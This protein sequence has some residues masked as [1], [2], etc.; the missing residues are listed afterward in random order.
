MI[1]AQLSR[2]CAYG[3]CTFCTY[4]STE[5]AF[6]SLAASGAEASVRLAV[7]LGAEV[8]FKDSLLTSPLLKVAA[9]LCIGRARWSGCTKLSRSLVDLMP[10][11]A[12]SG[13]ST[14]ELGLETLSENAQRLIDKRQ[15]VGLL[16]DVL[17]AAAAHGVA[18]VV[19]VITGFPGEDDD[20]QWLSLL[21]EEIARRSPRLTVKVERNKFQLERRAPMAERP[22]FGLRVTGA[23]P[24]SS[25]LA[26][27]M[28]VSPR[29]AA[30][31]LEVLP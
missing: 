7:T 18:L 17:D 6:R 21:A 30:R 14:L 10:T 2:G 12:R 8:S 15:S 24:W 25:V 27:E 26:W 11:L 4:P 19:N 23:W 29:G 3:K 20:S 28:D 5:G 9:S 1:P 13:C 22:P 16:R 31:R